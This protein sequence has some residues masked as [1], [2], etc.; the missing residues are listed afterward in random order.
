M[1][2]MLAAVVAIH[3]AEAHFCICVPAGDKIF[4]VK[5]LSTTMLGMPIFTS[6]YNIKH[7]VENA[8]ACAV[9]IMLLFHY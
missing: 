9:S 4:T 8:H 1:E 6:Y 3:G 2:F 7:S 5:M